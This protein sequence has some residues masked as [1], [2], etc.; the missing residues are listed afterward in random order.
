MNDN[1]IDVQP[2]FGCLMIKAENL[3]EAKDKII[4][5]LNNH[6]DIDVDWIEVKDVNSGDFA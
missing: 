1:I 6:D 3:E 4:Q 2:C 5:A